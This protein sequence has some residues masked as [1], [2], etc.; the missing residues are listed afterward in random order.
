MFELKPY[1]VLHKSLIEK[2]LV[3]YIEQLTLSDRMKLPMQYALMAGGKRLRPILC[4]SAC[5]AVGGDQQV[6]LPAACALEMIHTYSLIHDDLPALDNDSLRR[7]KPT[8]HVH[9]DEAT[10]ILTGDAL[11][12][13]SF[14]ILSAGG[15]V[16][17]AEDHDVTNIGKWLKIIQIISTAAGCRGMIEG[18]SQDL[19]FEGI[20]L[21][22]KKLQNLH[23]L[24]TGALIRASVQSGAILGHATQNQFDRLTTYSELIG[25]AFQVIDDV[26]NEKGDP[27]LLGKAV[28]TDH[29]RQKNTYPALLG[30][31]ESESYAGEL[32]DNALQALVA[33]DSKADPLRAIASYIIER[34]R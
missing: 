26:L 7:G 27:E 6:A 24:K 10:A 5:T 4:L 16:L 11:L 1:L 13:A 14:E 23:S 25:L 19:A 22:Q 28:G 20:K 31:S 2:A 15:T 30:L 21:D 8:C 32:V 3:A 12:T 9:F 34:N 17:N 33:F 29:Q 18:Q